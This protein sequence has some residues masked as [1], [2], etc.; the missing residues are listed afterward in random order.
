[1]GLLKKNKKKKKLRMSGSTGTA[2]SALRPQLINKLPPCVKTCPSG[3]D[4]RGWMTLIAQREKLGFSQEEAYKLAFEKLVATNPFPSMMGRVCPHPC[5]T[6]CNREAKD[7]AVAI[8]CVERFIGDWA[9]EKNIPLPKVEGEEAKS[10]SI[11][12]IGA[13]P[14]GLSFAYQLAR[15]GYPVTVYEQNAVAGGM[16]YYGIPFY[17]QPADVLQKEIDRIAD[18]GVEIKLNCQVG[19]D[20]TVDELK[21][22]HKIVFVGVGAHKGRLL[23]CPGEE[24]SGVWTGTDYLHRVNDGEKVDVGKSSVIIGG[25]DTAIDAARAARRAGAEVTIL[26]RRTRVEMPAI[27][28]EIED[29][30]KEDIKIEYLVA[31]VEIKRDGDNVKAIVVQKMELGEPDDSGRRRPVPI[32]GSEYDI[33][34]N[35]VIAAISQE[36]DWIGIE[37]IGPEERW[38]KVDESGKVRDGVYAG[39]D[40]LDLS[41]ATT[42]I[43]QGRIAALGVHAELSGKEEVKDIRPDI[44]KERIKMELEDVYPSKAKAQSSHRPVADWISKPDDEITQAISEEQFLEEMTRCFSCGQCFG[45]ERCWMFCTPSCFAKADNLV[46]A[47]PYYPVDLEKCDG[48]TKCADECPCGFIDM[49]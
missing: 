29:A 2:Q 44:P 41:I 49:V 23:G 14:A 24:G 33:E 3:T 8:N 35:S 37:S 11:G 5:E 46:H 20:V 32:E 22:K 36:A 43:G 7:G 47:E 28:S 38:L 12:V 13:G 31:P 27:E 15:R 4:I 9:L 25:G 21:E 40:A 10:E 1:M 39:G 48:C 30:I 17:R 18:V 42:A 16:I 6:G 26:Y 45:C 34:V 19:K